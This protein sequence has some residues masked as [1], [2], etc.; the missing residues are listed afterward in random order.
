MCG[1]PGTLS[2]CSSQHDFCLEALHSLPPPPNDSLWPPWRAPPPSTKGPRGG[3]NGVLKKGEG[4]NRGSD[5]HAHSPLAAAAEAPGIGTEAQKRYCTYFDVFAEASRSDKVGPCSVLHCVSSLVCWQ[6]QEG[7]SVF[8][9]FLFTQ[10]NRTQSTNCSLVIYPC[11]S[12]VLQ[13]AAVQHEGPLCLQKVILGAC[14]N[15]DG[16]AV[17]FR[18]YAKVRAAD[19]M[20][21]SASSEQSQSFHRLFTGASKPLHS[22]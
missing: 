22:M 3:P 5:S 15:L 9:S 13:P 1:S 12:L 19:F 2:L 8:S 18:P 7:V 14:P 10:Q 16:G 11:V 20:T 4:A 21:G 17:D 6:E